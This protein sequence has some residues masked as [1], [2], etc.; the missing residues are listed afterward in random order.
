V[1]HGRGP[2]R[3][4]VEAL[5]AAARDGHSGALVLRGEAGIGKSAM[6]AYAAGLARELTVLRGTGIETES[7]LP[8]AGI[9]R[10]YCPCTAWSASFRPRSGPR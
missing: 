9:H 6:L 4:R 1:L 7:E 5:I 3:A 8:F 10:L 2:E